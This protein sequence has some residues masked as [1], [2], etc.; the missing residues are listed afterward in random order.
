MNPHSENEPDEGVVKY[1]NIHDDHPIAD[2]LL[3]QNEFYKTRSLLYKN[4]WI[5]ETP[6]GIGY[7]NLSTLA[8]E[9][10][11]II[12]GTQTGQLGTL[13]PKHLSLVCDWDLAKQVVRSTGETPPSSEAI[14]HGTIYDSL[15]T[16]RAII[17]IH[18]EAFWK[19]LLQK[20]APIVSPY[21]SRELAHEIVEKQQQLATQGIFALLNH[22]DGIFAFGQSLEECMSI[23]E[24]HMP[25]E[26]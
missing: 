1:S 12:T 13:E 16:V 7:G 15:K 9:D 20:Y 4:S 23:L 6:D 26:F 2:Y 25:L 17:H 18:H 21:G 5:G 24:E 3:P 11:F 19:S 8:Q 22:K 14:S 10:Q